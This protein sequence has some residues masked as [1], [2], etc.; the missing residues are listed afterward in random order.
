[1]GSSCTVATV[2]QAVSSVPY[3]PTFSTVSTPLCQVVLI[4]SSALVMV[5]GDIK[6]SSSLSVK[7]ICT[8][9]CTLSM[10]SQ[11]DLGFPGLDKG[12]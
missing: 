11:F 10:T 2:W 4:F 1:M 3:V 12:M 9:P 5:G 6:V 8:F 7:S